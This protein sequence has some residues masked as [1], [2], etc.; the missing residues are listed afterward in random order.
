[1]NSPNKQTIP[2]SNRYAV[3]C[4]SGNDAEKFLQSQ[5]T[6]DVN[7]AKNDNSIPGAY[8]DQRGRVLC[9]FTLRLIDTTYW[10][11]TQAKNTDIIVKQFKKYGLFSKIEYHILKDQQFIGITGLLTTPPPSDAYTWN[12]TSGCQV[13]QTDHK[14]YETLC[15]HLD[16]Q[17]PRG[18]ISAWEAHLIHQHYADIE[19]RTQLQ[20][21]PHMLGMTRNNGLCF[22][23]GCYLGQEIIA[24]TEHLGKVKRGLVILTSDQPITT[25]AG[26]EIINADEKVKGLLLQH[27]QTQTHAFI[28]L[29]CINLNAASEPLYLNQHPVAIA[30]ETV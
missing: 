13:I 11:L 12:I 16:T 18:D 20:F 26:D 17:A 21:T 27:S 7:Q 9:R 29:A 28:G 23:K 22:N 14:H 10:I 6:C 3:I 24:R 15:V 25:Q 30:C 2:L 1:M 4:V 5:F 19:P 8:C